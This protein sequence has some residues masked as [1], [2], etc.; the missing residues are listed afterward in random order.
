MRGRGGEG[1]GGEERS[2]EEKSN[3]KGWIERC[4]SISPSLCSN[5]YVKATVVGINKDSI[6][7]LTGMKTSVAQKVCHLPH[8]GAFM[9][10]TYLIAWLQ[11]TPTNYTWEHELIFEVSILS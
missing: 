3:L 8:Y 4:G 1:R 10:H 9:Q 11:S 7:Y 6:Q 5:P 2:D